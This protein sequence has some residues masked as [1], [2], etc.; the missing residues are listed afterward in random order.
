[1][2]LG[3]NPI[4]GLGSKASIPRGLALHIG[5]HLTIPQDS[6]FHQEENVLLAAVG[7]TQSKRNPQ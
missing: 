6:T 5:E 3:L 7:S 4:P 2:P 1:M